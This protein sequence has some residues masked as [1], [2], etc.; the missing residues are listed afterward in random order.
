[1]FAS[2]LKASAFRGTRATRLASQGLRSRDRQNGS[3][4]RS[5]GGRWWSLA[6]PAR[7][8]RGAGRLVAYMARETFH[9]SRSIEGLIHCVLRICKAGIITMAV[10]KPHEELMSGRSKV[11][12]ISTPGLITART[13]VQIQSLLGVG[14][15]SP[16]QHSVSP[17][18]REPPFLGETFYMHAT[19]GSF[20]LSTE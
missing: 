5:S 4:C 20:S 2:D 14:F 17:A 10:V 1:M 12:T 19:R 13:H 11:A 18:I 16:I 15:S 7:L 6:L 3:R 8:H 9:T